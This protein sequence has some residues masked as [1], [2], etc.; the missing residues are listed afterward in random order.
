MSL[1]VGLSFVSLIGALARRFKVICRQ[2]RTSSTFKAD[3]SGDLWPLLSVDVSFLWTWI[4]KVASFSIKTCAT[5][6]SRC[7]QQL[8][9][10]AVTSLK[11]SDWFL[12][13]KTGN[14]ERL[15]MDG[16]KFVESSAWQG[17][18]TTQNRWLVNDAEAIIKLKW[19]TFSCVY[20][21]SRWLWV[22]SVMI[23]IYWSGIMLICQPPQKNRNYTFKTKAVTIYLKVVFSDFDY[24]SFV[25]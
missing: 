7:L 14:L 23:I 24:F 11:A 10:A 5:L 3:R 16:T 22:A 19:M 20:F 4:L 8:L 15:E 17:E 18:Q 13:N 25:I 1:V 6:A 21:F 12:D 9:P 2:L